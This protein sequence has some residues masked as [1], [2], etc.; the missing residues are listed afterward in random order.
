MSILLGAVTLDPKCVLPVFESRNK[1]LSSLPLRLNKNQEWIE[2]HGAG[3][4][5]GRDDALPLN[6]DR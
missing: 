6:K 4:G 3:W 1:Q 2:N 5:L